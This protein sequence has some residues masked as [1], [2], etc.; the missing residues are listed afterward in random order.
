MSDQN[1]ASV[2][3]TLTVT[4]TGSNDGATIAGVAIGSVTEDT[5]LTTGG[6]LTITDADTGEA[7]VQPIGGGTY[8]TFAVAADG[9]WTYAL[10][11]A[12]AAVQA[13]PAGQTLT[14]SI[15]VTSEDG[16]DTEVITVTITGTNDGATIAGEISASADE[17][18]AATVGGSLS[19]SDVDTG[20]ALVQPIAAGTHGDNSYGTFEVAA[21]G[22]WAYTLNTAAPGVQNLADGQS[23]SDTITVT[24]ADG[25]DTQVITVTIT[26]TNDAPVVT[27]VGPA[28][29]AEDT[30][31]FSIDLLSNVS[32]IESQTLTVSN[33]AIDVGE[34][35]TAVEPPFTFSGSTL[36][37]DTSASIID[38]YQGEPV[39]ITVT[40][41]VTDTQG[42]VTSTTREI[43]F[44]GAND[45]PI[46]GE[47]LT[48]TV[49]EGS[50]AVTI[51]ALGNVTELDTHP[52]GVG[53][54]GV[55]ADL[56]AI[57]PDPL[58]DGVTFNAA[59]NE[60]TINPMHTAFESLGNTDSATVVVNYTVSDGVAA[61]VAHQATFT[62]NGTNDAPVVTG[63]IVEVA[64]EDTGNVAV[65]LLANASDLESQAL[66]TSDVFITS[67]T[68]GGNA[69]PLPPGGMPVDALVGVTLSGSTLTLDTNNPDI[70]L[71]LGQ[72][73]VITV[74]YAVNDT[75]G[76][77]TPATATL[78]L[79]GVNDLP[80]A[81]GG[82][83]DVTEDT[84]VNGQ[85]LG[86]DGDFGETETLTFALVDTAPAGF[87]LNL[88]GTYTFDA[89]S[90]DHIP[91]GGTEVLTL[92]Y[93]V[94]DAQGATSAPADLV[95]TIHGTNDGAVIGGVASGSAVE[96]TTVTA[97][98]ALTVADADDGEANLVEVP[99]GTAGNNGY[100]TFAV[101][102]T[103]EW[104]YTLSNGLPLV[105]ALPAGQT[106]TDS[107]T[108]M[109]ADGSDTEVITVTITGT[110]D[111]A[112]IG[113]VAAGEVTED[114]LLTISGALTIDDI[115]TGEAAVQPIAAATPGNHGFGTFEVNADGTW[116]YTLNNAHPD[117]QGL[118][119]GSTLLDQITVTSVDGVGQ[120][121]LE[122]I[123]NGNN[124]A[125]TLSVDADPA[126][127]LVNE[128]ATGLVGIAALATDP[129]A[130]N[131][132]VTYALVASA[133][134]GAYSGPFAINA[135][136]GEVTLTSALDA[137]TDGASVTIYVEATSTDGTS[138]I[139][140]FTVAIADVNEYAVTAPVD[141]D[142]AVNTI[143]EG[144][145]GNVGLTASASD[146]DATDNTV[147]FALVASGTGG[148]Y[149]G[150]FEIDANTGEVT[151]TS[152]L[153][154][155]ATG[156]SVSIFVQATS[157]DGSSAITE[158]SVAVTDSNEAPTGITPATAAVNE[159]AANG[160]VVATLGAVDPDTVDS[161]TFTL[162]DSAGGRFSIVGNQV[163]VANHILL[164]YEQATSHTIRVRVTDQ[165]GLTTE[166]E[167][168][169]NLNDVN[170][171]SVVGNSANN[172]LV[173]GSG[174]DRL[175]G[176]GGTDTLIGGLGNDTYDLDRATDIVI[177]NP[178]EGTDI[179]TGNGTF[180]LDVA[181]YANVENGILYG[182]GNR[183]IY[184]TSIVNFLYGNIGDNTLDGR[185]GGDRMYGGSG[186]DTYI[187]DHADDRAIEAV[188]NTGG[189]DLVQASVT[190][191]LG[192]FVENLTLTG[193]TAI[194][195]NGNS[196]D[197]VITGNEA[198]NTL[199]GVAGNDTLIGN[200]GNDTLLGGDGNDTMSGGAGDDVFS[201]G[202][203]VDAMDGGDGV[204]RVSY[205][206]QTANLTIHLDG[207]ASSGGEAE[208]D[209]LT[210]I[211]NVTGGLG[212]DTI[213]GT[214][215]A[216]LLD[217][218]AGNDTLYGEAGNDILRG[219]GG[220]DT[221]VG[222]AG[223]DSLTGGL[224][225]DVFVFA[226]GWGVDGIADF[227]AADTE[228]IDLAGV[229]GITDFAD[230][231]AN[232][233]RETAG[234][235]E[236]YDGV[237]IIRLT[238]HT[239]GEL[240]TG[241]ALSENDFR[242]A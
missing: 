137:E 101:S 141:V 4:I 23:L 166:Q 140:P 127:D 182:T 109:S 138:T 11:N 104:T 107:I 162:L 157:S 3:Q 232:H 155:E 113:G 61:P 215:D 147:T 207:T 135:G 211:E 46:V 239:L 80:V 145:T 200:G 143:A 191:S 91:V 142:A 20:E 133:T 27:V 205:T 1:A 90:Y 59:T 32:D 156:G 132:T 193:S 84:A 68:I 219:A 203:G 218:Q 18:A 51:S 9:V 131:N 100:G 158:F 36:S 123:I 98:G 181:N 69:I 214:A 189:A 220:N 168:V 58:P 196:L 47:P 223:N 16:S 148:L 78:T 77:S 48:A 26:G 139:T 57:M 5:L 201:G 50:S 120:I 117:V 111:G 163:R 17:D 195:G 2:A 42:G 79:T 6:T 153:D 31:V 233:A 185:E 28:S 112:F 65:D 238:G 146:A 22:V 92:A 190:H 97:S 74:S 184:G 19:V 209:V 134:G 240:G 21:N 204:D 126:D 40:Y 106:L 178:N 198:A 33:V 85:V 183:A 149:S 186:A 152:A 169:I 177:E 102:T 224:G 172:T 228:W 54:D 221:L 30:G 124:D 210:F 73:A 144:A 55:E 93:T 151:L 87:T 15:T 187:V 154:H 170:P 202:G 110:N 108:V 128:N 217:C 45:A 241:L 99:A 12:H 71:A 41:D 118:S 179:V 192:Q 64:T 13:L 60:L 70:D 115:D 197:N 35:A 25:S 199:N 72:I 227:D 105:Q 165:G 14:D 213:H 7:E 222:G 242:F 44:T 103:G 95:V 212:N 194:N 96:D 159:Y 29:A 130:T 10:N 160:T 24:S 86:T 66:S 8:G 116:T 234:V 216:N 53:I 229:T 62:V 161:H 88:D 125:V 164:D 94:T 34:G 171:E 37:L 56:V 67:M 83:N 89:A 122:V 167:I 188:G 43:T 180:D 52:D 225:D 39:T 235:L 129:D 231:V 226:D 82:S 150:P 75:Q 237:N 38:L 175:N 49:I 76:G 121:T 176:G 114:G 81:L 174:N 136:N 208:G 173:G 230:L 236:I 63:G 119:A 206:T